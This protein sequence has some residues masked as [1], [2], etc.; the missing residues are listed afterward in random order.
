MKQ[1]KTMIKA[2]RPITASPLSP[3]TAPAASHRASPRGTHR[4]PSTTQGLKTGSPPHHRHE[5][6]SLL[7]SVF[8]NNGAAGLV[9]FSSI[10]LS[11]RGV[12]IWLA[13][14]SILLLGILS[15]MLSAAPAL[16]ANPPLPL[17]WF[18]PKQIA[19]PF[20]SWI[21]IEWGALIWRVTDSSSAS[22]APLKTRSHCY[23]CL[24]PI[25]P[26]EGGGK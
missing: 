21:Y 24:D 14:M 3:I 20:S 4:G 6:L 13:E 26:N 25:P 19:L 15:G 5:L 16:R 11:I 23:C 9:Y 12:G 8:K 1:Q 7:I 17:L 10:K 2:R 22:S 18:S